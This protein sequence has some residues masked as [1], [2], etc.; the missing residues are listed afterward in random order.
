[1]TGKRGVLAALLAIGVAAA[2]AY[3]YLARGG[4]EP[5]KVVFVNETGDHKHDRALRTSARFFQERTGI[6]LG[7]VLQDR[8]PPLTTIEM[9]ADRLFSRLG[10]GRKSDGKALLFLWSEKERLFKIEVSYDLEPVFPDAL[11]R[12]LEEGARTFMLSTSP[13]ARRDFIVELNVTMALHYREYRDTG[14]LSELAVPTS[15]H[16][17]VGDH[18]AGGA[19]IV[20]RG[21][22][23]TLERVQLELKPLRKE[24]EG[25]MQPGRT[26]EEVVQRYLRSLELGIGE[27]NVPL[28]TEASRFFRMDKPHAPG[29]LQRIRAY[30]AKAMPYRIVERGD[31][32]VV[33]FRPNQPVL[34]IFLR[35]DGNGQWFVDEPK[36]WATLHLFQDGSSRLKYDAAAYAFGIAPRDGET[37]PRSIFQGKVTP[38]PLLPLPT[39]LKERVDRAE[40]QVRT[41][42][43]SVEAWIG[44]ADLLHFEMF[45]LQSSEAVYEQILRL[46][47]DR[48][49]IRW[50][51][52]DI[53]QMTS[54]VEGENREWCE[55]LRRDPGD[56]LA[57]WYYKWF[58]KSNYRDDPGTALC[59]NRLSMA[60]D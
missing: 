36:V 27:P 3:L 29:Y 38:P 7:I 41:N 46:D 19:G 39:N 57:L 12:R 60:F 13:Y 54:D 6:N 42:P 28:L 52:I 31:L 53:Y 25:E 14:R 4:F 18:L 26:P 50:R 34:P 30:Y 43:A 2:A 24:L 48:T 9:Q 21:Y 11:C 32:A 22:A 23:A 8:L 16:R 15:G 47:P 49:D 44:L 59:I 33:A 17:Y 35:R 58:R 37:A 40:S 1:M 56:G 45:W 5:G 51:L 10:L 55:V 20:G